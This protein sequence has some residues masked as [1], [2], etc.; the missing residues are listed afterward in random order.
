MSVFLSN[1]SF[2]DVCYVSSTA[3]KMLSDII[4][5]L[6][7]VSSVGCAMQCFVFCGLGLAACFLLAAMALDRG[8]AMCSPLPYTVL[9][10]HTLCLKKAAG[11]YLGGFLSSL[12]D[13]CSVYQHDFC[14][15]NVINHLFCDL[16]P[17]LVLSC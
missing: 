14:G 1:L 17:V 11:A 16:P 3:A 15:P 10:S 9:V 6:K 12:I 5:E 7:T 2:L 4:P 8:A 13:T